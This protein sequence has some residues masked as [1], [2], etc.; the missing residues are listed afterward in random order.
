MTN[1]TKTVVPVVTLLFL[2]V[3]LLFAQDAQA[4]SLTATFAPRKTC[5]PLFQTNQKPIDTTSS[6]K[7][8]ITRSILHIPRGG[9]GADTPTH[10][11][12]M[13][14]SAFII[15]ELALRKIFQDNGISFPAQ[16][17]GCVLLFVSLIVA[18]ILSPGLGDSISDK[19]T[20]GATFLAKWMG[21]FFVPGLVMLP[22]APA[23]NSSL[24]ASTLLD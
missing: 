12:I 11:Q 19:L 1:M 4:K 18:Q 22:L 23:P 3:G 2:I 9:A 8:P 20:P 7:D 14:V 10:G 5:Q 16:L 15:I 21:V 13:G 6:T 17:A 24:E